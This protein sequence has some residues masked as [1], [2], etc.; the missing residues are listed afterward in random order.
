MIV[1]EIV[2]IEKFSDDVEIENALKARGIEAL[3]WAVVEI[4]PDAYRVSVSY[5][6]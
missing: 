6:K 3:R 1:S 5:I 4:L 2:E